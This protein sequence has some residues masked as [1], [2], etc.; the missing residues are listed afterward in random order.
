MSQVLDAIS[1]DEIKEQ[2]LNSL[3]SLRIKESPN[4]EY[5]LKLNIASET[6]KRELCKDLSALANS[7]GGHIL[8]GIK[9]T[10]GDPISVDG[11]QYDDTIGTRL[12]QIIT[13]GISPRMQN[14]REKSVSLKNGK[15]VLILKIEPDGY[16]HQVKYG[17]NRYHRREGTITITMESAD[18]ETFFHRDGQASSYLR[19]MDSIIG[20]LRSK[21]GKYQYY[22]PIH[23]TP[24][25]ENE[26]SL[27]WENI[28]KNKY[29]AP[30]DLGDLIER[31]LMVLDVQ[32][33]EIRRM[34]YEINEMIRPHGEAA[35]EAFLSKT[36]LSKSASNIIDMSYIGPAPVNEG[37]GSYLKKIE[38]LKKSPNRDLA[39]K[40][41]YFHDIAQEGY[42]FRDANSYSVRDT[43]FDL[44]KA[45]IERYNYLENTIKKLRMEI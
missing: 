6:E 30:K 9:E 11:I 15:R 16:L 38:V 20:P 44:E 26:A 13:T 3:V 17:D 19:E 45:V 43:R 25:N 28:K 1:L 24:E 4:L 10:N 36:D 34:R 12:R 18:V 14:V 27:F 35:N 39:N 31:Y 23:V 5:K 32:R 8:F 29:L 7:Q 40:L 42:I 33:K 2:Q 21:I 22:E 37:F 41:S